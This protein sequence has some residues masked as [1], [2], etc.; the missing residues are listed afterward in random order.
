MKLCEHN[1]AV[2]EETAS[3]FDGAE[4]VRIYADG[5]QSY[6]PYQRNEDRDLFNE[7]AEKQPGFP[8][9]DAL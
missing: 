7:I 8:G 1:A 2:T 4:P 3:M 6:G 5:C 9:W